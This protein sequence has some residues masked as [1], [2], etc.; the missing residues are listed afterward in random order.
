MFSKRAPGDGS[1]STGSDGSSLPATTAQ[2]V[3][4]PEPPR[5]AP[6][7]PRPGAAGSRPQPKVKPRPLDSLN[8][9]LSASKRPAR[10]VVEDAADALSSRNRAVE[11]EIEQFGTPMVP[12]DFEEDAASLLKRRNAELRADETLELE[13]MRDRNEGGFSAAK[14]RAKAKAAEAPPQPAATRGDAN[15]EQTHTQAYYD[16]KS[17]IFAALIDAMDMGRI[18]TLPREE[19]ENEIGQIVNEIIAVK[20]HIMSICRAERAASTTSAMTCWAMAHS[21]RCWNAMT[22]PTSWSTVPSRSTSKSTARSN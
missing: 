9:D 3:K 18:V 19:A 17:E 8:V 11:K 6:P 22:S 10:S 2:P 12:E 21:S 16:L 7:P 4:K 14:A 1:K 20:G 5:R 13:D 15:R